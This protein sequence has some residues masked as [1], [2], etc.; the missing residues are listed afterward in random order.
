MELEN[1]EELKEKL[2]EWCVQFMRLE[3]FARKMGDHRLESQAVIAWHALESAR[4][5]VTDCDNLLV[6]NYA[7]NTDA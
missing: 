5:A 6:S 1:A 3:D 4:M 7:G 2:D